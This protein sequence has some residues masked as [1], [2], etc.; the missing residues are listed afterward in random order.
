[1][2]TLA[3]AVVRSGNTGKPLPAPYRCFEQSKM[4]FRRSATSMIAGKPGAFKSTLALNIVVTW[5]K[6][7][8]NGIYI[9]ADSDQ[10]TVGSRCAAIITGKTT[11]EIAPKLKTGMYT[12]VLSQ[13][14]NIHW[15]YRA[16]NVEQID[17]RVRAFEQMYGKFPDFIVM[18][19]LMNCTEGPADF[20]GQLTMTRD[21]DELAKAAQ[22]HV[23]ILHHTQESDGKELE[24]PPAR[25]TIHGKVSQFPRMILS[26]GAVGQHM[27]VAPV[28]NT[29]G[30]DDQTGR[31]Y[32]DF[33]ITTDNCQIDEVEIR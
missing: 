5:A 3:K 29:L 33:I 10:N 14:G 32:E 4:T 2:E 31:T 7:G 11:A 26:V 18:D 6:D 16:L 17:M 19:N 12:D 28:K 20:Q 23:M 1:M 15:E 25:W 30:P 9:A 24:H 22:A 13:I 21:L 8:L 27:M